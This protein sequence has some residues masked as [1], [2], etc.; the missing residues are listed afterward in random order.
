MFDISCSLQLGI[1][2]IC[3]NWV[4]RE[5]FSPTSSPLISSSLPD[6]SL[7]LI[8]WIGYQLPSFKSRSPAVVESCRIIAC[9]RQYAAVSYLTR[10]L[11]ANGVYFKSLSTGY[12]PE[13]PRMQ[14]KIHI[15]FHQVLLQASAPLTTQDRGSQTPGTDTP[16]HALSESYCNR[17]LFL[18]KPHLHLPNPSPC[19]FLIIFHGGQSIFILSLNEIL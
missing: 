16:P 9:F 14:Q 1:M 5:A 8:L 18:L 11:A 3:G 4:S 10:L 15:W 13:D 12:L 2:G 7:F 6:I 19:H 17:P